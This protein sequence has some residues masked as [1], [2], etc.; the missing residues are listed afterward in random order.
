MLRQAI[1]NEV[2]MPRMECADRQRESYVC[3]LRLSSGG[4]PASFLTILMQLLQ[5][6]TS[7]SSLCFADRKITGSIGYSE[8]EHDDHFKRTIIIE[9]LGENCSVHR[10][11]TGKS[12]SKN[13]LNKGCMKRTVRESRL[14]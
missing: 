1:I 9:N 14:A 12:I 7:L 3:L 4:A 11:H 13:R 8:L 6:S 10:F 5:A 2:S